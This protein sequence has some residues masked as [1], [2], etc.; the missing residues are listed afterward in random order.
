MH[1]MDDIRTMRKAAD[2]AGVSRKSVERWVRDGL[3]KGKP[4]KVGHIQATLVSVKAV[5][6]LAKTR[7]PGRPKKS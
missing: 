6:E 7:R 2:A 4:A 3:L 5:R 1:V